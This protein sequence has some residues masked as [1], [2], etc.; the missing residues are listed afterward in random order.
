MKLLEP[1]TSS[2]APPFEPL[3]D[4]VLIE[5][6]EMENLSKGGVLLAPGREKFEQRGRV[7]AIGPG[8]LLADGSR[9]QSFLSVGDVVTCD[10]TRVIWLNDVAPVGLVQE[11]H[12]YAKVK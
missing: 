3:Q 12:I 4:F 10:P 6:M 8:G 1:E 9:T 11:R 2:V 5:R 7:L